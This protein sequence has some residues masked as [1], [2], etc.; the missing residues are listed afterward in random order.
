MSQYSLA[1]PLIKL[2]IYEHG[3]R[4]GLQSN[5]NHI[6]GKKLESLIQNFQIHSV[7]TIFVRTLICVPDPEK[8]KNIILSEWGR[9]N[10]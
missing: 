8:S 2:L 5:M 4:I 1:T 7:D 3:L 6:Y 10:I 9:E